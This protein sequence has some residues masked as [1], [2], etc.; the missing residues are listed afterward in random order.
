MTAFQ[1]DGTPASLTR[2]HRA[3]SGASLL[4]TV[5]ALAMFG[6]LFGLTNAILSQE[7]QRQ[8]SI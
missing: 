7:S 4:E 8:Q 3:E 2:D 6:A 5:L 1:F